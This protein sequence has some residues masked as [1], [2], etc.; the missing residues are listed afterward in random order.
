MSIGAEKLE[1][2]AFKKPPPQRPRVRALEEEDATG[3]AA[4]SGEA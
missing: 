4:A 3:V 2:T 1:E